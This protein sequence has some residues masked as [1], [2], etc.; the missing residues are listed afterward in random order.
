MFIDKNVIITGA[1]EGIGLGI[2]RAFAQQRANL[3]LIA[4]DPQK[5]N[6]I[7]EDFSLYHVTVSL[8]S[9]DLTEIEKLPS[10]G[11]LILEKVKTVDVLINNAG[12]GR[13]NPFE[14]TS[15]DLLDKHINLNMKAPYILTQNLYQ[16]LKKSKGNIINISSY[17]SHR[18]LPGRESTAYSMTKGGID[19]FTKS[20]AFEAGKDGIRVNAIAPGSINTPLLRYNL[21]QL[22]EEGKTNFHT[23]IKYIYPM[24]SI[25]T[26]EDIGAAAVFIASDQARWIT[27]T[28]LSVDGGLTTN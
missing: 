2:A 27:G 17:F 5:L 11:K 16:S 1:T 4:R 8:I 9:A 22:S 24:G 7:K 6:N 10:I 19:S 12:I 15:E 21:E 25:G 18:M 28:I 26:V 3:V 20:L 14:E 13:F 23:M